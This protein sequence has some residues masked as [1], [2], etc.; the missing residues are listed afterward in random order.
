MPPSNRNY[1]VANLLDDFVNTVGSIGTRTTPSRRAQT[2]LLAGP[3]S[4]YAHQRFA[5]IHGFTYRV[6]PYDTNLGW[7]LIRIRAD[8]LA[9]ASDPASVA[10]IRRNVV[11]RFAMSTLA[12]FEARGHRP[13]YFKPNQYPLTQLNRPC[14]EVAGRPTNAAAFFK[15]WASRLRL[16]PLLT[17]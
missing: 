15:Q 6:L 2:Y 12:H 14:G 7:I 10:S 16:S 1:Y 8:A 4:R 5:R 3:T 11:E 17:R 9:P 13:M